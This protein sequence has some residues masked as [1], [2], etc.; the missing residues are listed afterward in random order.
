MSYFNV[1]RLIPARQELDS[2][3]QFSIKF[4]FNTLIKSIEFTYKK[5]SIEFTFYTVI[6][7]TV[8]KYF[9]MFNFLKNDLLKHTYLFFRMSMLTSYNLKFVKHRIITCKHFFSE[10]KWILSPYFVLEYIYIYSYILKW[11]E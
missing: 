5:K 3:W 2:F 8:F 1:S 6:Q 9:I 10:N 11:K 4:D 7:L